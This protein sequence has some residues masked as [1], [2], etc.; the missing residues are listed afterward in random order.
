MVPHIWPI[1]IAAIAVV[2][3]VAAFASYRRRSAIQ[4]FAFEHGFEY[5]KSGTADLL[6]VKE[7]SFYNQYNFYYNIVSGTFWAGTLRE[8]DSGL[9]PGGPA[10]PIPFI[11]FEQ[12]TNRHNDRQVIES[13][14]RFQVPEK[15]AGIS[16]DFT[17][18][19]K[20]YYS[21]ER[22][23]DKIFVWEQDK[24]C[25]A[26]AIGDFLRLAYFACR[27]LIEW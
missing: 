8:A 1:M 15:P 7:A 2:I 24:C 25:P 12:S 16:T 18:F 13:F 9:E 19:E 23:D 6:G 17:P 3:F 14:V 21:T 10:A 22:L 5:R 20:M 26:D 4:Q 27:G 11:Y